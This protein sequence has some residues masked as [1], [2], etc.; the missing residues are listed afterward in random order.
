[1]IPASVKI[2]ELYEYYDLKT[3]LPWF[4]EGIFASEWAKEH[5]LSYQIIDQK[6]LPTGVSWGSKHPTVSINPLKYLNYLFDE[7][8]ALGGTRERKTISDWSEVCQEKT[9]I[10]NCSGLGA[11]RLVD[12]R[13][14][15]K[16]TSIG[17][18]TVIVKMKLE[19]PIGFKFKRTS[20]SFIP[21]TSETDGDIYPNRGAKLTD[22][23]R[24]EYKKMYENMGEEL[25]WRFKSGRYVEDVIY[26]FG[27][28]HN[29]CQ[30][31]NA[32]ASVVSLK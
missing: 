14:K 10:I 13:E 21:S 20:D 24:T 4:K 11:K 32:N 9:V 26:E 1:E 3:E 30:K 15:E 2:E 29:Q 5:K 16:I 31:K 27:C 7:F 6:E 17:G 18:Q 28:S 12:Q 25:K 8:I 19:Q 22:A 23:S